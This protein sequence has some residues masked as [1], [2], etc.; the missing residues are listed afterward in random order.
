VVMGVAHVGGSDT[1]DLSALNFPIVFDLNSSSHLLATSPQRKVDL[2]MP[3]GTT[4]TGAGFFENVIGSQS[5]TNTLTGNANNNLLI[6]GDVDDILA[7]AAGNDIIVGGLGTD[8]IVGDAG[9]DILVGGYG[10]DTINA[11]DNDRDIVV[12]G[13]TDYDGV[14]ANFGNRQA[15]Q[16]IQAVWT[17]SLDLNL[18]KTR[19]GAGVGNAVLGG[20]FSLNTVTIHDDGVTDSVTFDAGD[21]FPIPASGAGSGAAMSFSTERRGDAIA[22]ESV[23][24]HQLQFRFDQF[25][26]P[27]I[28][29]A[30][31]FESR[32][33]RDVVF[34]QIELTRAQ[35]RIDLSLVMLLMETTKNAGTMN[36]RTASRRE[37]KHEL[38]DHEQLLDRYFAK[39]LPRCSPFPWL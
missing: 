17:A 22:D 27:N 14:A 2:Y 28:R 30:A 29:R 36:A 1:I 6:G 19:I 38:D 4:P 10:V 32:S 23:A 37:N 12:S 21:W 15:W 13:Y 31:T 16:Y 8:S 24:A 20:P 11:N 26:R 5:N 9:L 18:R 25:D 39:L 35:P 3:G 34:S 33:I 7:G